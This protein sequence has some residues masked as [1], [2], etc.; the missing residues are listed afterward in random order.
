MNV[1]FQIEVLT[2]TAGVRQIVRA[3][4]DP[5]VDARSEE[6]DVQELGA[7]AWEFLFVLPEEFDGTET[8][9][10]KFRPYGL[11]RDAIVQACSEAM[12]AAV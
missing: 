2:D 6:L 12:Q 8:L 7:G 4:C 11:T 5:T 9:F 1:A 10:S 3:E